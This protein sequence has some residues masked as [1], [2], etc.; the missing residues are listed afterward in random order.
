VDLQGDTELLRPV[1]EDGIQVG[2][3]DV[4]G[5]PTTIGI[6]AEALNTPFSTDGD[7]ANRRSDLAPFKHLIENAKVP[8]QHFNPRM[9]ALARPG[10]WRL[11]SVDKEDAQTARCRPDCSSATCRTRSDDCQVD[12][13]A[14]PFSPC[15]FT[16]IRSSDKRAGIERASKASGHR[17]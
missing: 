17:K 11:R 5:T 4:K 3:R 10:S 8:K 13:P 9:E 6:V 1:Q 12:H 16:S 2:A 7:S 15:T 14:S